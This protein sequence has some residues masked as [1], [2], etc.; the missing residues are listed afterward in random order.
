MKKPIPFP[1]QGTALTSYLLQL[2]N[3]EFSGEAEFTGEAAAHSAL[4]PS[5]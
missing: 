5:P 1:T 3:S 2:G 4:C